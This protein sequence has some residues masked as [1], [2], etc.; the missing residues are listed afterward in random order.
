MPT[1]PPCGR[2]GRGSWAPRRRPG[3]RRSRWRSATPGRRPGRARSSAAR[4]RRRPGRTAGRPALERH[5]AVLADGGDRVVEDVLDVV[6]GGVVEDL[7]Q[8]V[9]HDLD[10]A[11]EPRHSR[12]GPSRGRRAPSRQTIRSVPVARPH[13][14]STPIRSTMPR[15]GNRST[16][17][18]PSLRSAG[19]RS[20]TVTGSRTGAASSQRP[21][22]PCSPRRSGRPSGCTTTAVG[23]GTTDAASDSRRCA[24]RGQGT[25]ERCEPSRCPTSTGPTSR[26]GSTRTASRSPRP[27]SHPRNA[28]SSPPCSTTTGGSAP[29]S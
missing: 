15:A 9:A 10:V 28:P 26:T 23:L 8:V 3:R 12:P 29:P 24:R 16:A 17:W 27:C 2:R 13:L 20:T 14:A 6:A 5:R 11:S 22:P 18:P 1:G 19:A 4:R 25:L 21:G 7:A